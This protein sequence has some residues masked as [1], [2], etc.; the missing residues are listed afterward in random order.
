[1]K[2]GDLVKY[3]EKFW[4]PSECKP[5]IGVV[6]AVNSSYPEESCPIRVRWVAHKS[7][8]RDWYAEEELT[9]VTHQ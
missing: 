9:K 8:E 2:V 4:H 1:M 5:I 7:T 6:L 3:Q